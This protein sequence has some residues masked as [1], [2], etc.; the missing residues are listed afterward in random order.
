M[1]KKISHRLTSI[2]SM[3]LSVIMVLSSGS[4]TSVFAD[5]LTQ[6]K[7]TVENTGSGGVASFEGLDLKYYSKGTDITAGASG[8]MDYVRSSNSNG[9]A[10]NGIVTTDDA[11]C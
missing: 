8:G 1:S 10:A 4:F 9:K 5:T 2:V 6:G 11:K 7:W 3:V